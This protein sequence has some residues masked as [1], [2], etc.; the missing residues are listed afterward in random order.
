LDE[1]V[2]AHGERQ[3]LAVLPSSTAKAA[4]QARIGV[5]ALSREK[6]PLAQQ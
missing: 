2:N 5:F 1:T 6:R 3:R 4:V